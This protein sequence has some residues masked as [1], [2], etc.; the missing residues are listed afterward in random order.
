MNILIDGL[1]SSIE[2]GGRVVPIDTDFRTGILF[3]QMIQDPT[4]G[5]EERLITIFSLYLHDNL[6]ETEEEAT[7]ALK[8]IIT[9]Y[10]CGDTSEIE[11]KGGSGSSEEAFSYDYD[12]DYIYAAFYSAYRIDL[13]KE[14]LHWWQFR[15]LFRALPTDTEFMKI[16]GYR[17]MEIPAK[18]S[19]EQKAH[20]RKLKKLYALP[21]PE[22][23]KQ[24]ESD[25]EQILLNGGDITALL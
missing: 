23:R 13:A 19:K 8:E 20:Y 11:D 12:A 5:E 7:E 6:P 16:V 25:L 22:E 3:E 14:A 9:F 18:M 10:R 24:L 21:I 2:F 17:T 4:L 1:P 15:A